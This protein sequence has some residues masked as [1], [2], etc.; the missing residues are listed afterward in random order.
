MF[1]RSLLSPAAE[2]L[3]GLLTP[4]PVELWREQAQQPAV[5]ELERQ[6]LI[7]IGG[8][9]SWDHVTVRLTYAGR[10]MADFRFH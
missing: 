2:R 4:E 5:R 6:G 1:R 10:E 9:A 7:F 8:G 3:L